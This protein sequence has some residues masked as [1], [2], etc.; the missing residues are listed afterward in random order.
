MQALHS[1]TA[2]PTASIVIAAYD[3]EDSLERAVRSALA[4]SVTVEVL[5]VDDASRDGTRALAGRLAEADPRV[6][7]IASAANGG[8]SAARNLGIAAAKG[9]WVAILDADDAY[10]PERMRKL[11]AIGERHNAD[12]VADNLLLYDWNAASI[13]GHAL[14]RGG[15]RSH[16]LSAA[17]FV[18]NAITGMS[19]F[20]YGQLKPIFRRRF[21]EARCLRYPAELRHGEDFALMIDCLLA[22]ARFVLTEEAFYL[23]TQRVGSISTEGSG[24]TRTNLNLDAMRRH[25]LSL[26][27]RPRVRSDRDLARLLNR[28]ANAIRYQLSWNKVYPYLRARRPMSLI[29]AMMRDWRSWPMLAVHLLRRHQNRYAKAGAPAA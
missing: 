29:G 26:L 23:F 7:L 6:R 20:D 12:M 22:E 21:L 5:I 14:P 25:T 1:G 27:G 4:Q 9:D 11:V 16:I 2:Q 3:A 28:R 17:D 18:R 15:K 24:Q 19:R 13:A 10:L 8:P